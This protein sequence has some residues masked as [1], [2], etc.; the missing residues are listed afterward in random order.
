MVPRFWA[1]CVH[2]E[3][4]I[5]CNKSLECGWADPNGGVCSHL[6]SLV[7]WVRRVCQASLLGPRQCMTLMVVLS[8]PTPPHPTPIP[9]SLQG[10]GH[11]PGHLEWHHQWHVGW[12]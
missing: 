10:H 4:Q 8:T 2:R 3:G 9:A 7:A 6:G 11:R 1:L 5:R 12:G